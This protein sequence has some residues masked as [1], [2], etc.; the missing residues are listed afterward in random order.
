MKAYFWL[1]LVSIGIHACK[2]F[3]FFVLN[4]F[5]KNHFQVKNENWQEGKKF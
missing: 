1:L 2:Y 4:I 3:N 5:Y